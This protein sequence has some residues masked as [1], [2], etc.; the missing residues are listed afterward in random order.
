MKYAT[1]NVTVTIT[2]E[3]S[4]V[5][6]SRNVKGK[7]NHSPKPNVWNVLKKVKKKW[8]HELKCA[9]TISKMKVIKMRA[10]PKTFCTADL[11]HIRYAMTLVLLG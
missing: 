7:Y 8:S 4:A 1:G 9:T 2:H 10:E 5:R 11:K 3:E 6:L